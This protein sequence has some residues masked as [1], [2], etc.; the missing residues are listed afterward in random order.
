MSKDNLHRK[1]KIDY[2]VLR[3]LLSIYPCSDG[4]N[5][6]IEYSSLCDSWSINVPHHII[7]KARNI[8]ENS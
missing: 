4:T 5:M 2:S 3:E 1:V 8:L 6:V 7:K